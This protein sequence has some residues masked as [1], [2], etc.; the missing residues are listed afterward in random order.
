V[1]VEMALI[2]EIIYKDIICNYHKI[3]RIDAEFYGNT[4]NSNTYTK[5]DVEVALF[6]DSTQ[7]DSNCEHSLRTK[8]Y[9]FLQ[10]APKSPASEKIDSVYKAL[11]KLPEF[12]GAIDA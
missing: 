11:K 12:D 7:R 8:Q 1:E 4:P 5:M 3:T 6:K 10:S 9:H 2:K